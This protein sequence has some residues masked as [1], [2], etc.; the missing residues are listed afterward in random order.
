MDALLAR[1]RRQTGQILPVPVVFGGDLSRPDLGLAPS[2]LLWISRH[3]R[4]VIH[5]AANMTFHGSDHRREPWLSNL[6]GTRHM[7]EICRRLEI[8]QFHHISTAYVCG[9][10]NGRI[11][12]TELDVGQE[13]SNDY[14]RSK[15]EA[16]KLVQSAG[17]VQPATIYRPSII[18]GDSQTGYT[19]TFHGFY[20]IVR[21]A[22]TLASQVIVGSIPA[23]LL[24]ETLGMNNHQRKD[25]V[26]VDWVSAVIT[27]LLGEP[28]HHGKTYHLTAAEPTAVGVWSRAIHD[29]VE[30]YSPMLDPT[31]PTGRDAQWCAK[32]F[33]EQASV[34][35]EYWRGDPP[36]DRTNTEAAV[37]HLPCPTVD[38][39][40]LMQ[41]ARF[42]I[43]TRFGRR[44]KER[45][46]VK[47][48]ISK[49]WHPGKL[50]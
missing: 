33:R 30:R 7:L 24:V 26:P 41:M 46:K 20:A 9:L 43:Q 47:Y 18:V 4:G 39:G 44:P 34:Y 42:A 32:I 31:N 50:G 2:Q 36:F 10:R 12:E 5:S 13:F 37:S 48:Q 22:H 16:E 14:E 28:A 3:C 35:R 19:S 27:H 11:L 29:A 15:V 17:L 45:S 8:S 23:S 40:M 6:E 49:Q 1:W 25:Y 21:L 38:Y